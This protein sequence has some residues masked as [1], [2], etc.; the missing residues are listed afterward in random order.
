MQVKR[1]NFF[2]FIFFV[3]LVFSA[4]KQTSAFSTPS[5]G[6]QAEVKNSPLTKAP[7]A[8]LILKTNS[9]GN[10]VTVLF[11]YRSQNVPKKVYLAG[12]FND[13][14][15]NQSGVI[16]KQEYS[17]E[18]DAASGLYFQE[19]ELSP[20][21]TAYKFV[22][23]TSEEKFDWFADPF[24]KER[25]TDGNSIIDFSARGEKR[26]PL[27]SH[28]ILF[29]TV[30]SPP[31]SNPLYPMMLVPSRAYFSPEE[32]ICFHLEK[33]SFSRLGGLAE[34]KIQTALGKTM[35]QKKIDL[36][37]SEEICLER[38][39]P[40]G[41]YIAQLWQGAAL[42][43]EEVTSVT[44]DPAQ[45]VRYGFYANWEK[46][47]SSEDYLQ[48]AEQFLKYHINAVQFYDWFPAHGDYTPAAEVYEFD[49]FFGKK[50][51]RRDVQG[52][53]QA[54]HHF[55]ILPLAYVAPYAASKSV[56]KKF[57]D[58]MLY[59]DGKIRVFS[60]GGIQE[61]EDSARANQREV[62]FYLMAIHPPPT[63]RVERENRRRFREQTQL[64]KQLVGDHPSSLWRKH[65]L[66]ELEGAV[67]FGFDGFHVDSYGHTSR[68][69]Y[70]SKE[71]T[72]WNGKSI[73]EV[74]AALVN[75]LRQQT[76]KIKPR[77][78]VTFNSVSE[79]A[80]EEICPKEDFAFVENWAGHSSDLDELREM[81]FNGACGTGKRMVV[82][83]YPK[84]TEDKPEVWSEDSLRL[85]LGATQSGGGSLIVL[86]EPNLAGTSFNSL[87]DL[88]YPN[89]KLLPDSAVKIVHDY[90]HFDQLM[91]GLT[92]GK[93]IRRGRVP[94]LP[95]EG[96]VSY[97][98]ALKDESV[99]ASP[100]ENEA[101][102]KS[103]TLFRSGTNKKWT[104]KNVPVEEL[105]NVTMVFPVVSR[106]AFYAT[107]ENPSFR[108][109]VEIPLEIDGGNSW[110]QVPSL[111][112]FGV[113][114]LIP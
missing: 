103:F 38:P 36:S 64:S 56:Y 1:F 62:W 81:V 83:L 114:I 109:P 4:L 84:D 54:L 75:E 110:V 18:R 66:S 89:N 47:Y 96:T 45:D 73:A 31:L 17:M 94:F 5:S 104:E 12:S 39:L 7:S 3:S 8:P 25:D 70:F 105:K 48:R 14:A 37:R 52:K 49:P 61:S 16:K 6:N 86:G 97:E 23:E 57:P 21:R 59:E 76:H 99:T 30:T 44:D 102:V 28:T 74:L 35:V 101:K 53:I 100:P 111:K 60:S 32:K 78:L 50:I 20:K 79:F 113:L 65:I 112:I 77:S 67:R 34:L 42:L 98:F 11:T 24:V 90:Y 88:Y 82:A 93:N 19:V 72:E 51:E 87:S 9:S 33:S 46:V 41:G 108:N 55:G 106:R 68:E 2:I 58:P 10:K 85:I 63:V 22:E 26:A 95:Y 15:E 92:H 27:P 80:L 91:F 40:Q 69:K 29:H 107:P 43:A 71:Q 13:W